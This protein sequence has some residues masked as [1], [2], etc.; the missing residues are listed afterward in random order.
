MNRL[1][2]SDGEKVREVGSRV[3]SSMGLVNDYWHVV[4]DGG[5]CTVKEVRGEE[6]GD[7]DGSTKISDGVTGFG[8]GR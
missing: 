2:G 8:E 7:G 3:G 4:G 1:R 6:K 5:S